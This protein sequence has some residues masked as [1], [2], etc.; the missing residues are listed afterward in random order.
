MCQARGG[1]LAGASTAEQLSI[2]YHLCSAALRSLPGSSRGSFASHD[3]PTACWVGLFCPAGWA[4]DGRVQE[5]FGAR[6]WLRLAALQPD[7]WV[8]KNSSGILPGSGSTCSSVEDLVWLGGR[9]VADGADGAVVGSIQAAA[10]SLSLSA[11]CAAAFPTGGASGNGTGGQLGMTDCGAFAAFVCE[12][13]AST[14]NSTSP[15]NNTAASAAASS[16]TDTVVVRASSVSGNA[17]PGS[18][19]ATARYMGCYS[20]TTRLRSSSG[21]SS[22]APLPVLL[23]AAV[24]SYEA[25]YSLATASGMSHFALSSDAECWGGWEPPATPF[26]KMTDDVQC[27][28]VC[29]NEAPSPATASSP[30]G[31]KCMATGYSV[32]FSLGN[33]AAQ[34]QAPPTTTTTPYVCMSEQLLAAPN[35][36][37]VGQL[38][39]S[40]SQL[41]ACDALCSR[42]P[43]CDMYV[44]DTRSLA[45]ILL[46]LPYAA[47]LA[48]MPLRDALWARATCVKAA[49]I[50]GGTV[51]RELPIADPAVVSNTTA[52]DTAYLCSPQLS[53]MLDTAVPAWSP[54]HGSLVPD[55][56]TCSRSCYVNASCHGF[57]VRQQSLPDGSVQYTCTTHGSIVKG[58]TDAWMQQRPWV[59][60]PGLSSLTA[61]G[62]NGTVEGCLMLERLAPPPPYVC[63][64]HVDV[65][66][67]ELQRL[68]GVDEQGCRAACDLDEQCSVY[69]VQQEAP[70][71]PPSCSLRWA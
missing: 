42:L 71:A 5:G 60:L 41:S 61:D 28:A 21:A 51:L 57:V 20:P 24:G 58:R 37:L 46:G 19:P 53:S 36:T 30:P 52:T 1:H 13:P 29:T 35:A 14:G 56:D 31:P 9:S 64:D 67:W 34:D 39:V 16:T 6:A 38:H 48:D 3:L 68:D 15:S 11:R 70:E 7:K 59:W 66:G 49:R 22:V 43:A 63:S 18:L 25:C 2:I 62:A 23:S 27:R 44:Y 8:G 33:E 17:P 26:V 4:T 32:V 69:V 47:R 65:A 55:A 12:R 50:V 54:S 10:G 45:C 40:P